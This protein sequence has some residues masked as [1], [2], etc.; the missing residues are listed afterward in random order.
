M[1]TSVLRFF[2]CFRVLNF[3]VPIVKY[4]LHVCLLDSV[5]MEREM[6]CFHEMQ[7]L[8]ATMHDTR[9]HSTFFKCT[10]VTYK[11]MRLVIF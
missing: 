2:V 3:S 5:H 11:I 7:H 1:L 8:R 10:L 9:T 6:A 4:D